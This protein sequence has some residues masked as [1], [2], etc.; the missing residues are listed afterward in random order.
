MLNSQRLGRDRSPSQLDQSTD[1]SSSSVAAGSSFV[2]L[3]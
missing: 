2:H 3:G 1:R